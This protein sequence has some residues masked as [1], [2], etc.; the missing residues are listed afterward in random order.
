MEKSDKQRVLWH[1]RRGMLELDLLLEPFVNNVFNE[2][3][4][5]EQSV[6]SKLLDEEDK[7]LLAWFMGTSKPEDLGYK[8]LIAK[9]LAYNDR[10]T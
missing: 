7:D 3:C 2:L 6:Y 4:L 1:S 8:E 5:K 9:I 10:S